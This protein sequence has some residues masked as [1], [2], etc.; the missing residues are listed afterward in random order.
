MRT[1]IA[2]VES[3]RLE[4]SD[5]LTHRYLLEDAAEALRTA[6][7]RP[8]GFVKAVVEPRVAGNH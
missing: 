1:A 2:L 6:A 3:G 4:T 8:E 5:L 7:E